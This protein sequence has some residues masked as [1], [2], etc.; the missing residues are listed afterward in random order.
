MEEVFRTLINGKNSSDKINLLGSDVI[1]LISAIKNFRTTIDNFFLI[2]M[3]LCVF[4][5]QCGF[6]L[7]EAGSVRIKNTTN[8]L[9]K[10]LLDSRKSLIY[11]LPIKQMLLCKHVIWFFL[12]YLLSIFLNLNSD[13]IT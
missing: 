5:M 11:I 9:L 3:A 1:E 6:A 4:L 12:Y 7:L 10:N 13:F 8:I 2:V